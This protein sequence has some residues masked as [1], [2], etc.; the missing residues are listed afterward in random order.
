MTATAYQRVQCELLARKIWAER[1]KGFPK[2]VQQTWEQGT[3]L[4]RDTTLVEAAKAMG[5]IPALAAGAR[6]DETTQLA[7]SE[8]RQSGPKGNAQGEAA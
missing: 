1:E 3:Q 6:S 5:L 2:F 4:A 7:Q 8:G